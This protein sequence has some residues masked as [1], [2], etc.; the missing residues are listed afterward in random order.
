MPVLANY[1]DMVVINQDIS[2]SLGMLAYKIMEKKQ[3]N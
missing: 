1:K 2:I 3:A